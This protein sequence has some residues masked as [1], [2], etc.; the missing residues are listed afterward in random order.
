MSQAD[1]LRMDPVYIARTN[2]V[3]LILHSFFGSD[4]VQKNQSISGHVYTG[5]SS[6]SHSP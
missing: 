1:K 5:F 3:L 4:L 6:T 2:F